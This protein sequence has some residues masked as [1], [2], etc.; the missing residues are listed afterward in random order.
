MKINEVQTQLCRVPLK[1]RT[2]T[3]SQS[4]VD[5]VE[6]LQ[7][8]IATDDGVIGYGMNWS[9]T[10]GLRAA[11]V[12]VDDNYSPILAGRDPAY[13]KELVRECYYSNHFIGRVGAT[14]VGLAAV[15]FALWD[16]ACKAAG[17]PL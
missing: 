15:E 1:Q 3:D 8:V 7:V 16:I 11:Q 4:R 9:Y 17:L 6:F 10:P 14:A 12:A 2:I 5:A 13:R